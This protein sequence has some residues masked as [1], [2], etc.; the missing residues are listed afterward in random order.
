MVD[1]NIVAINRIRS[2]TS[3]SG[4]E[5]IA[6]IKELNIGGSQ[7]S[8]Q[9]SNVG[10]VFPGETLP[11]AQQRVASTKE[12]KAT[13]YL[14]E[15]AEPKESQA[16]ERYISSP[17]ASQL[18]KVSPL[19][20]N[21]FGR[22]VVSSSFKSLTTT[23]KETFAERYMGYEKPK[24]KKKEEPSLLGKISSYIFMPI[25][26]RIGY[27]K[28]SLTED[29]FKPG[30]LTPVKGATHFESAGMIKVRE[31]S[32]Q[33]YLSQWKT[34]DWAGTLD[35]A[36]QSPLVLPFMAYGAGTGMGALKATSWAAKP[37]VLKSPLLSPTAAT[38]T[39][40]TAIEAGIG[41]YFGYETVKGG[42]E[43]YSKGKLGEYLGVAA[44][45]MPFVMLPYKW[46]TRAG[47]GYVQRKGAMAKLTG[48]ERT[49]QQALIEGMRISRKLGEPRYDVPAY[50]ITKVQK[51]GAYEATQFT[52]YIQSPR[53]KYIHKTA[54][55]GSAAMDIQYP[56]GFYRS[57]GYPKRLIDIASQRQ[58]VA[59]K[60]GLQHGGS[61]KPLKLTGV[62]GDIDI[63]LRG[64]LAKEKSPTVSSLQHLS[65]HVHKGR[66]GQYYGFGELT[67]PSTEGFIFDPKLK[68][69]TKVKLLSPREQF[70]RTSISMLPS[71]QK[72]TGYR[73]Y[74]DPFTWF[75]VGESLTWQKGGTKLRV[76]MDT[77]LYPE[78]YPVPKVTMGE[79]FISRIG[80]AAQ[81]KY[82]ETMGGYV[83]PVYP[84]SVYPKSY[85][86]YTITAGG[87]GV[88]P[89]TS[90][91]KTPSY[92]PSYKPLV[93][94]PSYK[95]LSIIPSYK[96]TVYKPSKIPTSIPSYKS[97]KKPISSI[98]KP[99][100]Y[101]P[102]IPTYKPSSKPPSY[103]PT[104]EPPYHP[105]STP[106]YKPPSYPPSIP[107]T[108][109]T[110][111]FLYIETKRKKPKPIKEIWKQK[112]KYR[113]FKLPDLGK[114][115]EGIKI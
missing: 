34:G 38:V 93:K 32:E 101:P 70:M 65:I 57:G 8:S 62:P 113:Q 47:M 46:G 111:P 78:K 18:Q 40:G 79:R 28:A 66:V 14:I 77:F 37:I 99:P 80:G 96:S 60:T 25:G 30:T 49:Q 17:L 22:S 1:P 11:Q 67:Y 2:D 31:Q 100:S 23:E 44:V 110:K 43:A 9:T 27:A 112:Y 16:L 68:V 108:K 5:K 97:S 58:R 71:E 53:A 54:I 114:I 81:P 94:P 104:Y 55:G 75:D 72:I 35:R 59:F 45:T 87:Y 13:K 73:S 103:P 115:M 15:H 52:K 74:K 90:S 107:P 29:R 56:T 4:S 48:T 95:P 33:T 20:A 84:K 19:A 6:K 39:R 64:I 105:P 42:V 12:Q 83:K 86:P 76:A 82:I 36:V 91:Y 106:P 61:V 109:T 89:Y 41:G 69:S 51:V 102:S 92:I 50:D 24:P 26:E 10:V 98:Y 63:L 88:T 7:T 85:V 21:F 3:L